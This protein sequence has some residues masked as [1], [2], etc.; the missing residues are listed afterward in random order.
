MGVFINFKISEE[1]E[2]S[3]IPSQSKNITNTIFME[4]EANKGDNFPQR[5]QPSKNF[6]RPERL[7]INLK[8]KLK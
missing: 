7:N 8:E 2:K 5:Q 6:N 3:Y 1:I 4:N